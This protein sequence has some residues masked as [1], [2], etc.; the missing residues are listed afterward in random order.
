MGGW[1]CEA[2]RSGSRHGSFHT[3]ISA[4]DALLEYQRS[5]GQIAVGDAMAQGRRFFLDHH[6]YRSHSTGDEVNPAFRRFL[7]PPQWH[8]DV[9]RGLEHFS[10]AGAAWDERLTDAVDVI[11]GAQRKDGT[12]PLQRGYAGKK[13]FPLEPAGPSRWATLRA[14]RV[15]EWWDR[16]SARRGDLAS[17]GKTSFAKLPTAGRVGSYDRER[18]LRG[19]W[20]TRPGSQRANRF[21]RNNRGVVHVTSWCRQVHRRCGCTYRRTIR[22]ATMERKCDFGEGPR[23]RGG[24]PR[25]RHPTVRTCRFSTSGEPTR[26]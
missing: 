1:D 10:A 3:S 4:L 18:M 11:R 22:R 16:E 8:F 24:R 6:L 14:R 13:W 12:W 25:D 23:R 17:L 15:L 9:L 21:L 20:V 26:F 7:F 19:R 5:G 2:I